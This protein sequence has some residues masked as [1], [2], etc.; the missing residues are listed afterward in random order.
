VRVCISMSYHI[1]VYVYILLYIIE[2]NWTTPLDW[3]QNNTSLYGTMHHLVETVM[4]FCLTDVHSFVHFRQMFIHSFTLTLLL[5]VM[6]NKKAKIIF[7][8]CIV[9]YFSSF[10][11]CITYLAGFYVRTYFDRYLECFIW[12]C[13]LSLRM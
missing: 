10:M 5:L 11:I 12:M 3:L 13:S 8:H 4:G 1:I 9:V 6:S 2:L 7:C